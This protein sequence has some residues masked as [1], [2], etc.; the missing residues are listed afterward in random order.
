MMTYELWVR[1]MAT[2][3]MLMSCSVRGFADDPA[4]KIKG[5]GQ[6]HDPDGDCMV[7]LNAD[8]LVIEFGDGGHALD[9]E[10]GSMNSPRVLQSFAANFSIQVTVDG[11]LPLPALNGIQTRAYISGGLV[12]LQDEKNYIRFERASFTRQG[13]VWHYANFEQRINGARTRMGLFAD[14][15]LQSDKPVELRL[16]V[17][18]AKV[19]ALVRHVG[20]AWHELGVARMQNRVALSA[21]VSGVKTSADKAKVSFRNLKISEDLVAVEAAS[22]S[23]IDL[24]DIQRI[25]Q[26]PQSDTEQWTTLIDRIEKLRARAKKVGELSDAE[27]TKL[28]DEAKQLGTTKTPKLKAYLGPSTAR[29]LAADFLSAGLPRQAIRVYREFAN[30]LEV[31]H[32]DGL[33]SSITTLRQSAEELEADL[34]KDVVTQD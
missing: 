24:N 4:Q 12:L 26:V 29:R 31:L 10:T 11:N 7:Q 32:E 27:Q 13:D 14:F 15:P 20:E 22:E 28:I 17:N 1:A 8:R 21:G 33:A 30:A 6:V 23:D 18:G 19:R 2:S 25:I 5:W 9:V 16:E 34:K 3:L